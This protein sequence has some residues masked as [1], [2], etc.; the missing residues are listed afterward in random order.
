[1]AF[2]GLSPETVKER[3][4][5]YPPPEKC[6][7]LDTTT[8]NEEVWDLLPRRSRTVDL[9]FQKIQELLVQGL[10]SLSILGDQ[11]VKDLQTG[12]LANARQVL[13][14]VMDSIALVANANYKLNMKRREL[15]KPDL[16]PPHNTRLCKEGIKP[17]TK[18]FGDELSKHL[19]DMTKAKKA[20]R[21]MQ[22]S[23]DTR[24]SSH[25]YLK[26]GRQKF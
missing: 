15:I 24:T 3:V 5:K 11:L 7:F 14:Q 20:G 8:I 12:K 22:R 26:A 18:L 21:Q 25:N 19:K 6:K 9:A 23:S 10:S 2:G 16:N 4:D 13:D 1:M 17:S